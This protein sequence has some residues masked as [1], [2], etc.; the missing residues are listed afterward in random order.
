MLINVHKNYE[1]ADVDLNYVID[2]INDLEST[3]AKLTEESVSVQ[4]HVLRH[5]GMNHKDNIELKVSIHIPKVSFQASSYCYK[6]NEGI[7][8]V[9]SKLKKQI[10]KYKTRHAGRERQLADL[11][12]KDS[13]DFNDLQGMSDD[14][15]VSSDTKKL[16]TKHMLFSDLAPLTEQQALDQIID[17]NHEF[18]V[19]V[20]QD[21]DRY[22]VIYKRHNHSGYA[23]LELESANGVLDL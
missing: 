7:E 2:R 17:L 21:T 16:I 23:I 22:N 19:F 6:V 14:Q 9:V 1:I 13:F 15:E 18:M 4:L 20:N 10:S 8:G 12:F 11:E 3:C 5:D